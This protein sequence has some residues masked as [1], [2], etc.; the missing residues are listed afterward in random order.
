[1]KYIH[2]VLPCCLSLLVCYHCDAQQKQPKSF[3][4]QDTLRGTLTAERSWWDVRYY[5][6]SV[7]PD[8]TTKTI[9]GST[10]MRFMVLNDGSDMQIDLQE[11]MQISA[12][13]W[14]S[15]TL[16]V[17]RD[18]NVYR[19]RFPSV[20]KKGSDHSIIISFEGKPREAVN[21]PWDGGWIWKKDDTGSPWMSVACQ[22]LGASVWYPCKD[23]QSD[24]PDS[25]SLVIVVPDSLVGVGNGRLTSRVN[26][27]D[28]TTSYTWNIKN[29]INNYNIIPYIGKYVNWTETVNG[30]KGRLD[31]S[32]WVLDYNLGKAKKQFVQVP[33]TIRCFEYWFGPYP[34]YEDSYKL[35]ESPHLGMEHQSAVAYGNKFA[36]GY[37]GKDLSATGWGLKWDFIIVHESGHEWFGN[38]ITTKDIADMWVH[39]GFTAYSETLYTQCLSGKDA[40]ND[41]LVGTRRSILNDTP[42]QGPYGVNKEG[43]SDMYVKGANML[44]TIRSIV[45]NDEAFRKIL[46]GLNE[47]YYHQTVSSQ[48]VEAYVSKQSGLDLSPVFEQ[49]LRH[50]QIPVLEYKYEGKK[51][52]Y[53]WVN[54]IKKFTMPVKINFNGEKWIKPTELWQSVNIKSGSPDLT[55]DRNFY[56]QVKKL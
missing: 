23:H 26:N 24:E 44:H 16:S 55:A 1:M 37:L 32:Y 45:N 4:V 43:S 17:R 36:N 52:S 54:C 38:N 42:V 20:L 3:S 12:V 7:K 41:Y 28:G 18:N 9:L 46:R 50:T 13:V 56:I 2:L 48:Q 47:T 40:G 35:V 34:F 53:R 14:K 15:K 49:Y 29:P 5:G 19:L 33:L 8:F 25:A 21:P 27:S 6:I 10:L 39:E 30:E 22:G 31:C 51:L 11:P